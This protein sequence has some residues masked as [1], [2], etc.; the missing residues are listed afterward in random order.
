M[1]STT[2]ANAQSPRKPKVFIVNPDSFSL[3]HHVYQLRMLF[4][5][6]DWQVQL[7]EHDAR[8]Y[9]PKSVVLIPD[10]GGINTNV[11]YFRSSAPGIPPQDQG[12]ER[13][14]LHS[15]QYWVNKKVPILGLGY[16]AFLTFAELGGTLY[17]GK[18]G[19]GFNHKKGVDIYHDKFFA[20]NAAGLV[21]YEI[22]ENIVLLAESLLPKDAPPEE[23]VFVSVPI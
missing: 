16:S 8:T 1:F 12:I 9:H 22:D 6:N 20:H 18:D 4:M 19:L 23:E 14:R 15:M 17:C 13:F 11:S 10:T 2:K 7:L 3:A 5:V 21:N